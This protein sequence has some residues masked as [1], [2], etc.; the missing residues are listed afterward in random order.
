MSDEI[1][2]LME[3]AETTQK[4]AQALIEKADK[5][6]RAAQAVLDKLDSMSA[7]VASRIKEEAARAIKEA[8]TEATANLDSRIERLRMLA[9][10]WPLIFAVMA[11]VV[12]EAFFYIYETRTLQ[13]LDDVR[14]EL[15]ARQT[16]LARTPNVIKYTGFDGKQHYGVEV[17]EH[18]RPSEL[19]GGKW[20]ID[21]K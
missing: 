6:A 13:R 16:E 7:V 5:Q 2:A 14:A 10:W 9:A 15:R 8:T 12:F 3:A 4:A 18:S 21:F 17:F 1:F 19:T 11:L 20:C